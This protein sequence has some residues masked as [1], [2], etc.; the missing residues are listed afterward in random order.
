MIKTE[1]FI[2]A[3]KSKGYNAEYKDLSFD[4][5]VGHVVESGVVIKTD[6]LNKY[7]TFAYGDLLETS[8]TVEDAVQLIGVW[9]TN[10]QLPK[11][12]KRWAII[13]KRY[14]LA[15]VKLQYQKKQWYHT[16]FQDTKF[17]GIMKIPVL[18]GKTRHVHWI[19]PVYEE[20]LQELGI[21]L[22]EMWDAAKENTFLSK[23]FNVIPVGAVQM[24]QKYADGIDAEGMDAVLKDHPVQY[25]TLVSTKPVAF[26]GA[27]QIEN[28]EFIKW[29]K[30]METSKFYVS[31]INQDSVM[32]GP[33]LPGVFDALEA[34]VKNSL[35]HSAMSQY[36]YTLEIKDL[37]FEIIDKK[38]YEYEKIESEVEG[39][40][41]E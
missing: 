11:G 22:D 8:E 13:N 40:G 19:L 26:R 33:D 24:M 4:Q 20:L 3:L 35:T 38:F 21:T 36:I 7:Y 28:P 31:F 32:L 10:S 41:N 16:P 9:L 29:A 17:E 18:T 23:R 14:F 1:D 12:I 37:D 5:S 15:N 25:L 6:D 30:E 27:I 2:E 34:T 39:N